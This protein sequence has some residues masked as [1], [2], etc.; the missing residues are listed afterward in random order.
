MA[1]LPAAS[2]R[3]DRCVQEWLRI[4]ADKDRAEAEVVT[5]TAKFNRAYSGLKNALEAIE[6]HKKN[7]VTAEGLAQRFQEKFLEEGLLREAEENNA[8]KKIAE[9]QKKITSQKERVATL[10]GSCLSQDQTILAL[11]ANIKRL[12]ESDRARKCTADARPPAPSKSLAHAGHPAI[13]QEHYSN[14]EPEG[15]CVNRSSS[16]SLAPGQL[17][18]LAPKTLVSCT[19]DNQG[20]TLRPHDT[21]KWYKLHLEHTESPISPTMPLLYSK[22]NTTAECLEEDR[23]PPDWEEPGQGSKRIGRWRGRQTQYLITEYAGSTLVQCMEG[24]LNVE[25]ETTEWA[26]AIPTMTMRE[27]FEHLSRSKFH[28]PH[29]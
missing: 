16:N 24:L 3:R 6:Q 4:Q 9:L 8:R 18:M 15:D 21:D 29:N 26:A 28:I 13:S 10:T 19:K 7:L 22:V 14:I 25:E 11:R 27:Q 17:K 5:V 12:K 20:S 23:P 1:A 2:E